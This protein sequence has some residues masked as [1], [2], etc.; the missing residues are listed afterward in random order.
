[1]LH[2]QRFAFEEKRNKILEQ[3]LLNQASLDLKHLLQETHMIVP[4][5]NLE[6]LQKARLSGCSKSAGL[7][8]RYNISLSDLAHE[9]GVEED[10][11]DSIIESNSFPDL[12]LVDG[13]DATALN[14][15]SIVQ[16]RNNAITIFN[17]T[18]S[19]ESLVYY[20]PSGLELEYCLD[21]IWNVLIGVGKK[22][23]QKYPIDGIIIPKINSVEE[24]KWHNELLSLIEKEIGV[25]EN[26]IKMQFLIE[27]AM[28]VENIF[29]LCVES[30]HRI[31]G[32]IFGLADYASEVG[33]SNNHNNHL[34]FDIVRA[35]IINA[36]AA[37]SVPA[38]DAMTFQYPVGSKNKTL[39]ENK[40]AIILAMKQVILDTENG[41]NLGIQGK[42]VGHPLQLLAVK[43]TFEKKYNKKD[44]N[45]KLEYIHKYQLA[46]ENNSGA[47]MIGEE[48]ADR[49]T[50]RQVKSFLRRALLKGKIDLDTSYHMRIINQHEY[51]L[52]K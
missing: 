7:L 2:N 23:L 11:W 44:I 43:A 38:I 46:V 4:A 39:E 5:S 42:W 12:I 20:R 40:R 30:R 10:I 22:D 17:E 41:M 49:A 21:D 36:S 28:G 18:F 35:K 29:D 26:S 32:V 52:L 3:R 8:N 15:T 47:T 37:I 16:A 31:T 24:L 27:S 6:M 14:E 45:E 25:P 9:T 33:I 48:M 1:M 13:E 19:K 51:E 50:E 34:S